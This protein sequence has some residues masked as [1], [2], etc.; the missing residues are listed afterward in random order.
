MGK[1][2]VFLILVIAITLFSLLLNQYSFEYS[3]SVVKDFNARKALVDLDKI[4]NTVNE[5]ADKIPNFIKTVFGNE[6]INIK[7]TTNEGT[8]VDLW[9]KTQN[10]KIVSLDYGE[11]DNPTIIVYTSEDTLNRIAKSEKPTDELLYAMNS[12][13]IRYET[14]T[15]TSG[16]RASIGKF[17]YKVIYKFK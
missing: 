3:G 11:L 4:K 10:A 9:V 14:K 16:I 2:R 8:V 7:L 1:G 17:L 12:G 5:N 15:V 13:E 6:N